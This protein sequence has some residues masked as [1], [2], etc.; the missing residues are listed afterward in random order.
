L[1]GQRWDALFLFG[2]SEHAILIGVNSVPKKAPKSITVQNTGNQSLTAIAPGLS[3]GEGFT[4]AGS[5][6]L[7]D[8]TS[9]FSLAAGASCDLSISF[10]PKALGSIQSSAV[11]T[12]NALNANP[13]KQSIT[14]TGTGTR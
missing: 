6:T 11:L 3:I 10:I 1:L 12:D 13:A 7:E 14:L 4:Q 9:S 8:C 2:A 5:A